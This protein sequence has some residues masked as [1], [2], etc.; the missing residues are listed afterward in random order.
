MLKLVA[1]GLSNG[2]VAQQLYVSEA[3]V[4]T[5]VGRILASWACATAYRRSSSR[6]RRAS[7]EAG[8][9][10]TLS[11]DSITSTPGRLPIAESVWITTV[12]VGRPVG[13][14]ESPCTGG[15]TCSR[16]SPRPGSSRPPP[17]APSCWPPPPTPA[18]APASTAMAT[19]AVSG[20]TDH[21]PGLHPGEPLRQLHRP[22]SA[23][24]R[25]ELPGRRVG[26]CRPAPPPLGLPRPRRPRSVEYPRAAIRAGVFV[27]LRS[28]AHQR[29]DRVNAGREADGTDFA[30]P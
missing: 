27:P 8:R 11:N 26:R 17:L 3:T 20:N 22:G 15:F 13:G 21:H 19:A 28:Y 5:H 9:P 14:R 10:V 4:K 6:T 2:E 7:S 16:S 12:R 30:R 29:R 1:R 23:I 24:S 25:A 18:S